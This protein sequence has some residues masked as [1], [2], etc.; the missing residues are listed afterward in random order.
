MRDILK[1]A[2][3]ELFKG[4]GRIGF[5]LLQ[6]TYIID[7]DIRP[8]LVD[9]TRDPWIVGKTGEQIRFFDK[10]VDDILKYTRVIIQVDCGFNLW[11]KGT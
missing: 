9:V 6:F 1:D 3:P 5:E 4:S 11:A 7:N 8:W 10:L 2:T